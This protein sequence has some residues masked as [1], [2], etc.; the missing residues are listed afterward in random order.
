MIH[1]RAVRSS[2]RFQVNRDMKS[3]RDVLYGIM[4]PCQES[5]INYAVGW[6]GVVWGKYD[7]VE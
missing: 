5:T 6:D 7:G 3:A 1:L 4:L 2:E